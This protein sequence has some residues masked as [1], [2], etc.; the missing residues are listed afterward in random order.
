VSAEAVPGPGWIP[1]PVDT[2][3]VELPAE[4]VPLIE[5]LAENAHDNWAELRIS[6]GWRWGKE[7][8]PEEMRHRLLVPYAALSEQDKESDR[9]LA[10]ETLKVVLR[11][12]FRIV[13]GE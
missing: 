13:P 6:E 12:G 1:A 8:K 2:S 5:R 11:I 7:T 9:R 10:T 3:A 4:L